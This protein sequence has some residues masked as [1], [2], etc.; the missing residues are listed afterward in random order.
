[1]SRTNNS[2][3]R[4]RRPARPSRSRRRVPST[5]SVHILAWLP[6]DVELHALL[7]ADDDAEVDGL[8]CG[9]VAVCARLPVMPY[10][11]AACASSRK[12]F[13]GRFQ[14]CGDKGYLIKYPLDDEP[15]VHELSSAEVSQLWRV[16]SVERG[17]EVVREYPLTE[18]ARDEGRL[19]E[20]RGKLARLELL[21]ENEASRFTLE[22][23]IYDLEHEPAN[24]WE[25]FE[26]VGA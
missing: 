23:Q 15:V 9:D 20:L 14:P 17:G 12:K 7:I 13:V 6:Q 25:G 11:L 10:E 8:K 1:M 3:E 5:I 18:G 22:K 21:P 26:I 2:S 19:N 16:V 4:K 24:E